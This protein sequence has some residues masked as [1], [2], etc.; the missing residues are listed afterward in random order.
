MVFRVN[1]AKNAYV[2]CYKTYKKYRRVFRRSSLCRYGAY[3]ALHNWSTSTS[4]VLSTN[5]ILHSL[6]SPE[7][8]SAISTVGIM[9]STYIG[10]DIIGQLGGMMYSWKTG[11]QAD[12]KPLPY[13]TKGALIDQ[14]ALHIENSSMLFSKACPELLLPVL[15]ISSIMH[16]TAF[17]SVAAVNAKNI[18]SLASKSIGQTYSKLAAVNT[19]ASTIGMLSGI[20]IL[21]IVPSYTIRSIVI[22]PVLSTISVYSLRK[23]TRIAD[24]VP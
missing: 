4:F 10:K 18:Q 9:T 6:V 17:V 7:R 1:V 22:L 24:I 5:S 8:S 15:G 19:L 23:A 13:V 12:K 14:C 20:S 11:K 21:S 16:N 2:D 3:M